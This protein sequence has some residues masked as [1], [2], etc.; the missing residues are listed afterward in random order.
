[1][2]VAYSRWQPTLATCLVSVATGIRTPRRLLPNVLTRKAWA[3][4]DPRRGPCCNVRIRIRSLVRHAGVRE[5]STVSGCGG[6]RFPTYIS[7]RLCRAGVDAAAPRGRRGFAWRDRVSHR[8]HK[9]WFGADENARTRGGSVAAHLSAVPRRARLEFRNRVRVHCHRKR[10]R[11]N[12][13]TGCSGLFQRPARTGAD[14]RRRVAARVA[15]FAGPRAR[16]V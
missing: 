10:A 1:M 16:I 14:N 3:L 7:C 2:T 5:H 4:Y 6:A 13:R 12:G 8:V 11:G 9:G 15:E